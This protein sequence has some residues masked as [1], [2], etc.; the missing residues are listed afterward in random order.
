LKRSKNPPKDNSEIKN[1]NKISEDKN[2]ITKNSEE[3][4]GNA[5]T[6]LFLGGGT[7]SDKS[8]K[9]EELRSLTTV[10]PRVASFTGFGSGSSIEMARQT[11]NE[12]ILC[13]QEFELEKIEMIQRSRKD[14]E[15]LMNALLAETR[16]RLGSSVRR[17]CIDGQLRCVDQLCACTMDDARAPRIAMVAA[18][19]DVRGDDGLQLDGGK[20]CEI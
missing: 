2:C 14:S 18:D 6:A 19:D 9:T 8:D 11:S 12:V 3:M 1:V 13:V 15:S 4:Q 20:I 17:T 5:G 10:R 16:S 7:E